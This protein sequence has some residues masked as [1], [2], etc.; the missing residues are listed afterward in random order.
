MDESNFLNIITRVL[1]RFSFFDVG[2]EQGLK[3]IGLG[4]CLWS[5][6]K[7]G[8]PIKKN[9]LTMIYSCLAKVS[10]LGVVALS[11]DCRDI[12]TDLCYVCWLFATKIVNFFSENLNLLTFY[13]INLMNFHVEF[14]TLMTFCLLQSHIRYRTCVTITRSW[15]E[16]T[17]EY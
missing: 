5:N 1:S 11:G 2:G 3:Y 13:F 15:L 6:W 10:I 17:L 8:P 4:R 7:I 12:P 16:T 9:F 14:P